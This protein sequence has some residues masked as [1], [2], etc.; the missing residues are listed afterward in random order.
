MRSKEMLSDKMLAQWMMARYQKD[1]ELTAQ[2][3][4]TNKKF[5]N[6][7][8]GRRGSKACAL[9]S[10]CRNSKLELFSKGRVFPV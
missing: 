3:R 10:V 8:N 7:K 2:L 6:E 4:T 9:Q 1:S 5:F